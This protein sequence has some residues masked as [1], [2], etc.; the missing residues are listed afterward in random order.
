M[1][2][3]PTTPAF[4]CAMQRP[5]RCIADTGPLPEARIPQDSNRERSRS[6]GVPLA[7]NAFVRERG[8]REVL[9]HSAPGTRVERGALGPHHTRIPVRGAAYLR[10]IADT[11]PLPAARM[12]PNHNCESSRISGVPRALHAF[13]RERGWRGWRSVFHN[14]MAASRERSVRY[15]RQAATHDKGQHMYRCG[16]AQSPRQR[17]LTRRRTR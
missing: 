2:S 3:V 11:G 13:V 5:S 9:H 8:W 14:V 15:A 16:D 12:P 1:R 6:S 7:L 4:P 10:C 17:C